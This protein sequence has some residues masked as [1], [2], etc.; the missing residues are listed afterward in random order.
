MTEPD[1]KTPVIVACIAAAAAISGAIITSF[2]RV[3]DKS[4]K[5]PE[6][7]VQQSIGPNSPNIGRVD[8]NVT[9]VQPKIAQLNIPDFS[10][11]LV[12]E[13]RYGELNG[14]IDQ[15]R[16]KLVHIRLTGPED[17]VQLDKHDDGADSV[18]F[19]IPNCSLVSQCLICGLV[20]RGRDH[21]VA[22]YQHNIRL[23]GY[24]V[25]DEESENHQGVW[26][27]L[28]SVPRKD[29]LPRVTTP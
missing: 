13:E 8:G 14:F 10:V 17:R 21:E 29:V 11:D 23:N 28:A 7:I 1:R 22:W 3:P 16:G 12:E 24:F 19:L 2:S 25:I 20:I 15:N 9:L 4:P 5:S 26:Y 27:G 18:A 6:M